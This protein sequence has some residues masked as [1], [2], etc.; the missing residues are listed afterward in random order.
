MDEVT[1]L[2]L[3]RHAEPDFGESGRICLGQKLDVPLSETGKRQAARLG[4]RLAGLELDGIYVS[5]LLRARQTAEALPQRCPRTVV[6]ELTEVSSGEWDG[7]RFAEIYA[8]YP[9]FFDFSEAGGSQTPPGGESD[10]E[11]LERGMRF[12][13]RLT[14]QPGKSYALVTH[15]GLGRILV[16]HLMGLPLYRKRAIPMQYASCTTLRCRSG[17]WEAELSEE[18]LP[19]PMAG[20]A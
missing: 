16:C 14:E 9:S 20:K 19:D 1:T 10:R 12:V 18:L 11:A 17:I 4:E 13:N 6:P 8:R 5:P 15:S 3:I 2:Y 7:M